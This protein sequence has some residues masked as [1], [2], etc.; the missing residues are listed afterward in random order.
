MARTAVG[1]LIGLAFI[2]AVIWSAFEATQVQC[3]IC[4]EYKGRSACSTAQ[5]VDVLQAEAQALSGACSQVTGG[6]TETLECDRLPPVT[7]RC[8]E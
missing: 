7:R 2:A 6:V 1:A 4:V 5:A 8:T 3:E